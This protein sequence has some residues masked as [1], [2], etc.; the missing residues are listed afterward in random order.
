MHSSKKKII[1]TFI[2]SAVAGVLF[3]S[4]CAASGSSGRT[5]ALA[6]ETAAIEA[7]TAARKSAAVGTSKADGSSKAAA[8]QAKAGFG[9]LDSFQTTDLSGNPVDQT[10]F[11]DYRLTMVNVWGTFCGPCI[12]EMPEL[13]QLAEEYRAKGV[14]IVGIPIDTIGQDGKIRSSQVEVAKSI[15]EKTKAAY[16]HLLPENSLIQV[17]YQANVVPTTIFVDRNGNQVG[18]KLAGARSAASWKAIIDKLLEQTP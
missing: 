7:T 15:V 16:P 14:Q 11:N 8:G 13:G 1:R 3:L 17:A 4:G 18:Q 9:V 12:N 5:A 6:R 10:I 2:V